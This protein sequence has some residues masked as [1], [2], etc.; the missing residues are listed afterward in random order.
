MVKAEPGGWSV[1]S[2][3][4]NFALKA[5]MQ[6]H[7]TL[8]VVCNRQSE[9]CHGRWTSG[10]IQGSFC[11][12]ADRVFYRSAGPVVCSDPSGRRVERWSEKH[13]MLCPPDNCARKCVA[14]RFLYALDLAGEPVSV[15]RSWAFDP[16]RSTCARHCPVYAG[17][18]DRA[19]L[20]R[21]V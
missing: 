21:T 11:S 18:G 4:K 8:P 3:A 13:N 10:D 20:A 5:S 14:Y 6:R 7:C 16:H 19:R 9:A 1:G 15:G 2:S 12:A 17:H